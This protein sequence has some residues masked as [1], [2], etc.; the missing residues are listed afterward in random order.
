MDSVRPNSSLKLLS[1]QETAYTLAVSVDD[2]LKWNDYN[3]LKPTLT[4]NGTVGYTQEQIDQ[5]RA[6]RQLPQIYPLQTPIPTQPLPTPL[7][8]ISVQQDMHTTAHASFI[9]HKLSFFY[10]LSL[11]ASIIT[12]FSLGVITQQS[13]LKSLLDQYANNYQKA[14]ATKVLGTQTSK[15]DMNEPIA[16]AQ[17]SG[18]SDKNLAVAGG[19]VF[20]GKIS[21]AFSPVKTKEGNMS[22]T[23]HHQS[24]TPPSV[25]YLV[26][27]LHA[28]S[29]K[30]LATT[31]SVDSKTVSDATTFASTANTPA[32]NNP[33]TGNGLKTNTLAMVLGGDGVLGENTSSQL[34]SGTARNQFIFVAIVILGTMVY[35]LRK[36]KATLAAPALQQQ[37][38]TPLQKILEID[39]K[40]DGTVVLYFQG[41]DYK[42]SKPE[43]HSDSDQ[44]IERLMTL[45]RP[46]S[47]E[48]EFDNFKDGKIKLTTP[49]SRLVTRLGFVG[50][51][52][53]L[54]FPRTS[55]HNVLFRKYITADDLT[56]MHL[57]PEQV[58]N[59]L[60]Q[61]L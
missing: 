7:P 12:L 47:K 48:I 39:Q 8:S 45:S 44:F 11:F 5:F 38:S 54:F 30:S 31:G 40:M 4:Q 21:N 18:A 17:T 25:P 50:I 6:I 27:S 1:L 57:T 13:H 9:P 43:L 29:D 15:A 19:S 34:N 10:R 3:I 16:F 22:S 35:M 59:D 58:F 23:Q 55:K 49:L 52:R 32:S 2:L 41:K 61:V 42:I 51:K 14:P 53:D 33:I 37:A 24:P 60:T 46:D 26:S 28:S 20:N 36:P 56:A